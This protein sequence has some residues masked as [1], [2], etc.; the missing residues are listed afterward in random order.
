MIT[1]VMIFN[2]VSVSCSSCKQGQVS[3]GTNEAILYT[4]DVKDAL[5]AVKVMKEVGP[6]VFSKII[7]TLNASL[8][9]LP[10]LYHPKT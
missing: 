8:Q 9:L 3:E 5:T 1:L 2:N 7:S 6:P 4:E 10:T